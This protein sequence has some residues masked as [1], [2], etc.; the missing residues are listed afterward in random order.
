MR[1]SDW[2]EDEDREDGLQNFWCMKQKHVYD[3]IYMTLGHPVRPMH[4]INMQLLCGKPD[5]AEA[6]EVT[7]KMGLHHLMGLQCD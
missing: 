5:F 1:Q 3:D 6:V 4:P 7:G 2:F